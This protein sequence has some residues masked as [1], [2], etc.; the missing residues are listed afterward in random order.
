[1]LYLL[2]PILSA[3]SMDID[4]VNKSAYIVRIL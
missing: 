4:L 3:R 2:E 1:M